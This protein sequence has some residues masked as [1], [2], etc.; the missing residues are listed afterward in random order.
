MKLKKIRNALL[1]VLTLAL[2][3]ATTVAITWAVKTKVALNDPKTNEFTN[4]PNIGLQFRELTFDTL[5]FG[6]DRTD[7]D[8]NVPKSGGLTDDQKP[9]LPNG[10]KIS[11]AKDLGYNMA[12]SYSK[13]DYIPK[14]PQLRNSTNTQNADDG[15]N[16]FNSSNELN[17]STSDEW[18]ALGVKYT[19]KIP[20]T[21][22]E[23]ND[24]NTDHNGSAPDDDHAIVVKTISAGTS[25][26]AYAGATVTFDNYTD[27]TTAIATVGYVKDD[28]TNR[29]LSDATPGV[30]TTSNATDKNWTDIS[31]NK[32]TLFM[33][34]KKVAQN[35]VT[36]TLFDTVHI[37]NVEQKY[38][39]A[40][41]GYLN[42]YQL[43][44]TAN[45]SAA[46]DNQ[47]TN[48]VIYVSALPQFEIDLKGYAVQADN[49]DYSSDITVEG[50]SAKV[51]KDFVDSVNFNS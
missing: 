25:N 30:R 13:N 27:F 21:V 24:S 9:T 20:A 10:T 37:N 2:V 46:T 48:K 12:R 40:G 33:Y 31:S 38:V 39:K 3:S 32:G 8:G 6:T 11:D 44:I 49:V 5:P 42:L 41:S 43:T 22:Y 4:N 28:A 7:S 51:L 23:K 35:E 50:K 18:V 47:L 34:N 29:A 26:T 17:G 15:S 19:L 45:T 1:V 16:P 36:D 14:N